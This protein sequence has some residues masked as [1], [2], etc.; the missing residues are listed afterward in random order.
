MQRPAEFPRRDLTAPAR[1]QRR[2]APAAGGPRRGAGSS[3]QQAGTR[4][5]RADGESRRRRARIRDRA[6][7][8]SRDHD[9]T[10][11]DRSTRLRDSLPLPDLHDPPAFRYARPDCP[12]RPLLPAHPHAPHPPACRRPASGPPASR[13]GCPAHPGCL[14]SR[15]RGVQRVSGGPPFLESPGVKRNLGPEAGRRPVGLLGPTRRHRHQETDTQKP[16]GT[17]DGGSGRSSQ[18]VRSG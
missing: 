18:G 9:D 11:D 10:L 8:T 15:G 17:R 7:R 6:P 4:K 12:S 5:R 14:A 13:L 1:S 16:T 2:V 3:R